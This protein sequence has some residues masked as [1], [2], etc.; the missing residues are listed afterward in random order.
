MTKK[1]KYAIPLLALAVIIPFGFVSAQITPG[2]EAPASGPVYTGEDPTV[3]EEELDAKADAIISAIVGLQ[4][5]NDDLERHSVDETIQETIDV[6]NAAID[7]LFAELDTL[8]PPIQLAEILPED[9]QKMN[10][11]MD[12]LMVSNLPLVGFGINSYT[13]QL[14]VKIDVDKAT[15]DI[16]DELRK[17]APDV[18]MN[19]TYVKNNAVFQS[20]CNTTTKFC[21]PLIGGSAGED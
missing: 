13:G 7:S 21:D 5:Q 15:P 6:N 8:R 12:R 17:I 2:G 14:N 11:A 9:R 1:A 19:I 20:S 16:E 18:Q 10:A 3:N 4:V